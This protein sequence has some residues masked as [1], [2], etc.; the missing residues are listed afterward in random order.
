MSNTEMCFTTFI[1]RDNA[2]CSKSMSSL[3]NRCYGH[4][5]YDTFGNYD[6][7]Q[8]YTY[9][10]MPHVYMVLFSKILSMRP[11]ASLWPFRSK[12]TSKNG[13]YFIYLISSYSLKSP[14]LV[15]LCPTL[16]HK[17]SYFG[18]FFSGFKG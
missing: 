13:V 14:S 15:L 11:L 12:L 18:H 1:C 3:N 5:F 9:L 6:S 10:Q 8:P 4:L 7:S 17:D 16:S 2:Y